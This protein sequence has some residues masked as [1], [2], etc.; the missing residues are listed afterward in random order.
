MGKCSVIARAIRWMGVG[1]V[2]YV[3]KALDWI[4][5]R[6]WARVLSLL[7]PYMLILQYGM[8]NYAAYA[9]GVAWGGLM[10]IACTINELLDYTIGDE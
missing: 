6:W 4:A 10:A 2:V 9:V 7:G 3:V 5:D 1:S 8:P